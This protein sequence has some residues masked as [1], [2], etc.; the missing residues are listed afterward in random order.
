MGGDGL[1]HLG[2]NA[3][4]GTDVPLGMIPSGTGNDICRG[5]DLPTDPIRAAKIIVDGHTSKVDLAEVV[6]RLSRGDTHKYVGSTV[7]SGYDAYVAFRG[8]HMPRIWGSLTYTV[9]ALIE[10]GRFEPLHYRLRIDGVERDLPAMFIVVGNGAYCGGGMKLA[11]EA[12]VTSGTLAVTIIHPLSRLSMLRLLLRTYG[13]SFVKDPA[14]E[15]LTAKEV[16]VDGEGLLGIADGEELGDV[17]YGIT[18]AAGALTLF[19]PAAG[20]IQEKG[21]SQS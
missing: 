1:I 17:P 19:T 15:L 12:S 2:L 10:L 7:N 16:V 4:G 3:C 8:A 13:G 5:M 6:G 14:V 9:A 18:C 20:G 21:T 11:P